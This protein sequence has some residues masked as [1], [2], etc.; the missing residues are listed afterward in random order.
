MIYTLNGHYLMT[1]DGNKQI[2]G[3]QKIV[4][5]KYLDILNIEIDIIDEAYGRIE[6]IGEEI[7]IVQQRIQDLRERGY[8]IQN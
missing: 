2:T 7:S 1:F 4:D 3:L 8:E 5:Q 6:G